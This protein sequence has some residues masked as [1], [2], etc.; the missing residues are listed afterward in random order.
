MDQNHWRNNMRANKNLSSSIATTLWHCLWATNNNKNCPLIQPNKI[1]SDVHAI[2]MLVSFVW[3]NAE[4]SHKC[5]DWNID[6]HRRRSNDD[7]RVHFVLCL[8][9][10]S[11]TISPSAELFARCSVCV[12][13]LKDDDT[14]GQIRCIT[15]RL[16]PTIYNV[17]SWHISQS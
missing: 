6:N 11:F 4:Y 3:S 9:A 2:K 7:S 5:E 14:M 13:T 16:R 15:H 17:Q 8:S 10:C 12:C 1:A